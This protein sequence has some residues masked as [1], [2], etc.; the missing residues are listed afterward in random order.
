MYKGTGESWGGLPGRPAPEQNLQG[1]GGETGQVRG[2]SETR[3]FRNWRAAAVSGITSEVRGIKL[4]SLQ[5]PH[6]DE[7]GKPGQRVSLIFMEHLLCTRHGP[8]YLTY[9][10]EFIHQEA[11][12]VGVTSLFTG[13][14]RD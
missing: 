2:D 10:N 4:K 14:C 8:M 9:T 6:D 13:R 5:E 12:E 11:L 3:C 7:P 1:E